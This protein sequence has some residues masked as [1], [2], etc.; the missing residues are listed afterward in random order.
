MTV[1]VDAGEV[2][3]SCK[4]FMQHR[5]SRWKSELLLITSLCDDVLELREMRESWIRE[6][7]HLSLDV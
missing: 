2:R 5:S 3:H 1:A 6:T 4:S 7:R